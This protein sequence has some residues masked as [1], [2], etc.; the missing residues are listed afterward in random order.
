MNQKIGIGNWKNYLN[1]KESIILSKAI[2]NVNISHKIRLLFPNHL[3]LKEL[4]KS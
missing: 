3:Y 1:Y 2:S 4:M